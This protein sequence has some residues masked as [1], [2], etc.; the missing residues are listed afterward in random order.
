MSE[1]MIVLV[2][3]PGK[4]PYTKKIQPGLKSLQREVGGYI[5]AIYPFPEPVAIVCRETGKLDG[6][7]LNRTLRDESGAIY[8]I[9]AGTFLVVGLT[10]ENFGSLSTELLYR[11]ANREISENI[12]RLKTQLTPEQFAQVE[13]LLE[14]MALSHSMELESQFCFGFAAGVA[15]QWEVGD[16]LRKQEK[17]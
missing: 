14:Q 2:V 12:E 11:E 1:T 13:Q 15:L 8:D 7:P 3:E 10:E 16:M 4:R 6:C 9:I 17:K 5:E